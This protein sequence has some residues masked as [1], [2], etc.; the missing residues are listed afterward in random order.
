[1]ASRAFYERDVS[2]FLLDDPAFIVGEISKHHSQDIVQLQTNAW[3]FQ[4]KCLKASLKTFNASGNK[5]FFEFGIP[6]MGKRADVVLTLGGVVFVLE[7][8]VNAC[9][10]LGTDK[11]QVLDYC[12][13]LKHFHE[14]SHDAIIVPILIADQTRPQ[15]AQIRLTI[16]SDGLSNVLSLSG[17]ELDKVASDCI[18]RATQAISLNTDLRLVDPEKWTASRYK[19]TPTIVEAAQALFQGHSVDEITRSGAGERNLAETSVAIS[20]VIER[21]KRTGRK[22]ICF[23]TG[24]PGAGKTLAGL[25]ITTDRMRADEDEHAVFLSGNGPLVAVL[26]E[27]LSRDESVRTGIKKKDADRKAAAF[28][29]NI[30]HFRDDN[31]VTNKPPVEKVVVFDEAQRAWDKH[32]TSK[33]MKQKRQQTDFDQSEPEFLVGVMDRH[34]DWCVIIALIGGGQEINSGEAGLSEWLNACK[35]KFRNWDIYYSDELKGKEYTQGIPLER[36]LSGMNAWRESSL[37]LGISVR[38]FRAK[39]LSEFV[40]YLIDNQPSLAREVLQD[41]QERFPI[42]LTRDI[43]G[44]RAWLKGKA[45]GSELYGLIASSG[46]HRLKPEGLNIKAK[47]NPPEWFLNGREDVRSCHYLEDIATE[48]DVQGLEL[49]WVGVGWDAN[50]RYHY[51][52]SSQGWIYQ[53]FRGTKWQNMS[54]TARRNY[55][56]NSYRVLLTRAR[57]GMVIFLPH[58]NDNDHTRPKSFYEGTWRYLRECGIQELES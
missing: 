53:N 50:F 55:L 20:R 22:S 35:T 44:A 7:F 30:H 26:R 19:P 11:D 37:H 10:F 1:M 32:A 25:K 13:D 12:L 47:V 34:Q 8:K 38:S 57:Q 14:G 39:R 42:V 49:D 45:R 33:F 52:P 9:S 43:D 4:I 24:V 56:A 28:I 31:L 17:H 2:H 36:Q 21:S 6:R 18:S 27:A 40:G 16:G 15:D 5:I 54:Q 3:L 46:A 51:G 23:V 29:Q 58:G 48:F 41:V